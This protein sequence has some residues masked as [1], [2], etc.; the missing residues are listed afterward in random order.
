MQFY[1][2]F[3][4][5]ELDLVQ[6]WVHKNIQELIKNINPMLHQRNLDLV[7]QIKKAFH[8]IMKHKK[9]RYKVLLESLTVFWRY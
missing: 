8:T 5:S 2:S 4:K 6:K 7:N 3:A 1:L 9:S